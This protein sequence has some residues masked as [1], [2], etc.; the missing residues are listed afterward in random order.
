M[1]E[2]G[3]LVSL[4]GEEN[5]ENLKKRIT[6][7]IVRRV[8]DDLDDYG[9]YLLYPP[10]ICDCINEA[11]DATDRK[12]VKMYKDAVIEINQNYI[13]KMKAYMDGQFDADKRLRAVVYDYARELLWCGNEHSKE[14]QVANRLLEI[15][16]MTQEEI[17]NEIKEAENENRGE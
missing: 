16:G 1:S 13:D 7:L 4:L 3:E 12:I 14:R 6:D 9:K 2:I 8:E 15:L 17:L 11:L 5:V 10:D